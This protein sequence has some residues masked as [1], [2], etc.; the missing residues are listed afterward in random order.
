MKKIILASLAT[1]LALS[2][3]MSATLNVTQD[4][5]VEH[6]F[7]GKAQG[8]E[9]LSG[10]NLVSLKNGPY[11]INEVSQGP[12]NSTLSLNSFSAPNIPYYPAGSVGWSSQQSGCNYTF[13]LSAGGYPGEYDVKE[14]YT[15]NVSVDGNN[16]GSVTSDPNSYWNPVTINNVCVKNNSDIEVNIKASD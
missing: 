11:Q 5:N 16:V 13:T 6:E 9:G 3:A 2:T 14:G 8:V 12:I 7:L 4:S 10:N 15:I 1:S